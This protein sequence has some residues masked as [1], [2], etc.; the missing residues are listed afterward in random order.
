M[1]GIALASIVSLPHRAKAR[2]EHLEPVTE[3]DYL[4]VMNAFLEFQ[5]FHIVLGALSD[6]DGRWIEQWIELLVGKM[7][8]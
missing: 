5:P 6:D 4:P 7:N 2:I 3:V 1:T 8:T